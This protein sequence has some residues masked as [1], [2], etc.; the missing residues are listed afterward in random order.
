MQDVV[1]SIRN[2][3]K[4][5]PGVMALKDV[6]IDI[7]K[8]DNHAIVG[9][10]G[11]GKSTLM[12][13]LGG[14]YKEDKGEILINNERVSFNS[15]S[16]SIAQGISIVHQELNF[17][18]D[19][20]VAENIFL[21]R[22]PSGQFFIKTDKMN[23]LAAEQ[24]KK[25]ESDINP[26]NFMKDLST[27][28]VQIIEIA[29]SLSFS[30]EILILDEPTSSL[31]NHEIEKLFI[32]LRKLKQQGISVIYISHKLDEIFKIS[33]RVTVMRDGSVIGTSSTSEISREKII[34][35]MVGRPVE[36]EFPPRVHK[37]SKEIILS[38]KNLMITKDA[39]PVSFELKRGEVLGFA[40]LVGAGRT[41]IAQALFGVNKK[42][43]G[44]IKIKGKTV[45][46]GSPVDA[47]K[48]GISFLTESRA[49]G[50]VYQAPVTWNTTFAKI[51]GI[52]HGGII[53][54]PLERQ[55]ARKYI[56]RLNTKTSTLKQRLLNFSGG[57]QQKVILSKWLFTNTDILI[58]DEPTR[59][60]DVGAKYEIY[61]LINELTAEGKSI[62]FISSELPEVLAMSDRIVIMAAGRLAAILERSDFSPEKVMEYATSSGG[63]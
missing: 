56:K 29:R 31:S 50:I 20:S 21:G 11:A 45:E 61:Q 3:S 54:F 34:E 39:P 59:G 40:G 9:E 4:T 48:Y 42:F 7:F 58:L 35:M 18:P 47:I 51:K 13:I 63:E 36:N 28:E 17:I 52:C 16:K 53:D 32:V 60:I 49:E 25:L 14:V 24:L 2:I 43:R 41:E 22:I 27:A 30:P 33:D 15:V 5:F 10:N 23:L 44:E 57:N 55:V 37:S 12:K 6:S 46:I 1:L 38:V 8:G 19:L 62:I 26:K